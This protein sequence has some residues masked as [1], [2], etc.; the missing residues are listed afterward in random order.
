MRIDPDMLTDV[1]DL[2]LADPADLIQELSRCFDQ[3]DAILGQL[4]IRAA[5]TKRHV[6]S[7]EAQAMRSPLFVAADKARDLARDVLR[8]MDGILKRQVMQ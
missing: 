2:K 7:L 4:T 8:G 5:Q 6:L 3:I 1:D